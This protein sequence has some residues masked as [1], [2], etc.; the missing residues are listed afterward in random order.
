[1]L[2]VAGPLPK[3]PAVATIASPQTIPNCQAPPLPMILGEGSSLSFIIQ[4]KPPD[5]F[6]K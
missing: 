2:G 1:M 6:V 5:A 4:T 3:H